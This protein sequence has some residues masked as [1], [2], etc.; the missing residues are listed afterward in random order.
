[1]SNKLAFA[2]ALVVLA[3]GLFVWAWRTRAGSGSV[4]A[5][6]GVRFDTT[7]W[8]VRESSATKIIWTN[9]EGDVLSLDRVEGLA[10]Y[11]STD[12]LPSVRA[13]CRQLA[14]DND[15]GLVYADF[16]DLDGAWAVSLI[17]KREQLP[18]YAY[19]GLVIIPR[20][21]HHFV[22]TV[23][24]VERGTTGVRDAIV[25]AQL[26]EQGKLDPT[27]IDA[28]HRLEGWFSDPYDSKYNATALNSVADGE[29]YDSV[30]PS[31]PLSK[32]RGML[33]TIEA[34]MEFQQ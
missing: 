10:P 33:R 17:Y 19:T 7:S 25:T 22:V 6:D 1:M 31:H 14:T 32:V 20:N 26:L 29:Q 13:R 24:S 18:A 27:K 28:N 8:Q 11:S 21:G 15:G 30:V 5:I 3:L 2:A 34:S 16:V 23:A 4:W 12:D 9:R